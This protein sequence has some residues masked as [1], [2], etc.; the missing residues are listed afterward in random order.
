MLVI[1]ISEGV[2]PKNE[3]GCLGTSVLPFITF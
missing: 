1:P 2:F 3:S